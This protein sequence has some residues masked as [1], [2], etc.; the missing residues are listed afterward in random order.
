MGVWPRHLR[1][2]SW[3]GA[4]RAQGTRGTD[5]QGAVAYSV[6]F[7]LDGVPYTFS[8][9][10]SPDARPYIIGFYNSDFSPDRTRYE[11]LGS[12]TPQ[13]VIDGVSYFEVILNNDGD[14]YVSVNFYDAGGQLLYAYP[15]SIPAAL[16][17]TVFAN[18][19]TEG[20]VVTGS[21]A[22][23]YAALDQ[24]GLPHTLEDVSVT[25]EHLADTDEAGGA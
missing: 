10:D 20:A 11:A 15:D 23:P 13:G 19:G 17:D 24:L 2:R 12:L 3:Q 4:L 21:L 25:L 1:S 22:G 14:W 9:S 18:I 7:T 8:S 6:S 16:L 5:D